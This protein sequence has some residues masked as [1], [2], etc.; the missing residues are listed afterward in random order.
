MSRVCSYIEVA[1]T[2]H[3]RDLVVGHSQLRHVWNM[4]TSMHIPM[5][6]IS[7]SGGRVHELVDIIKAQIACSNPHQL[8]HISGMLWQNSIS[9]NLTLHQAA[10]H[11]DDLE[12]Y[13][14]AYQHVKIALPEVLFV[15]QL[16]ERWGFIS[17]LNKMLYAYQVRNGM[18][19][20]PLSKVATK[21]IKNGRLIRQNLWTE[22][23]Q[24]RGAGYH[25]NDDGKSIYAKYIR[26]YHSHG[27]DGLGLQPTAVGEFTPPVNAPTQ[28]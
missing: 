10:L 17:E 28:I 7:V 23:Q 8:L 14:A 25:L 27:F 22:F 6:W 19:R 21:N 1:A 26:G 13:A 9:D 16:H 12:R 15:P 18:D 20:Y 3:Q 2:A 24:G 4:G 5:D 11:I